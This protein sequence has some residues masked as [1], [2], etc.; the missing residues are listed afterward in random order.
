MSAVVSAIA[1]QIRLLSSEEKADLLGSL[2]AE[3]DGPPEAGVREAWLVEASRRRQDVLNGR[4]EPVPAERVFA[5]LRA[6]LGG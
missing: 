3:L 6:R 2:I 1:D 5:N 4:V